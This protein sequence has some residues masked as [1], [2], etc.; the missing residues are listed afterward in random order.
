MIY[1]GMAMLFAGGV[2]GTIAEGPNPFGFLFYPALYPG[3]YMLD[4]LPDWI[5]P[6][7]INGWQLFLMG[8]LLNVGV[9]FVIGYLV[10]YTVNR[11]QV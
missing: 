1:L 4:L 8:A 10:D 7:G 2:I 3:A 6:L 9:Y 11:F 5:L